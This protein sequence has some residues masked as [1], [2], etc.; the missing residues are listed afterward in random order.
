MNKVLQ[1]YISYNSR[2][3]TKKGKVIFMGLWIIFVLAAAKG[4]F[5]FYVTGIF[6]DMLAWMIYSVSGSLVAYFLLSFFD[7]RRRFTR[8]HLFTMFS[9]A[10]VFAPFSAVITDLSPKPLVTVGLIEEFFKVVPLILFAIFVP[11]IIRTKKD[12]IIYG[13]LGGIGFNI[14]EISLYISRALKDVSVTEAISTHSTRLAIWGFGNHVIWSAF[15]GL[16]IGMFVQSKRRGFKRWLL[17]IGIYLI[18]AV[19]HSAFDLGMSSVVILLISMVLSYFQGTSI[20]DL[21]FSLTTNGIARTS[22]ILEHG[23]YNAIFIAI[24]IWQGV[25]S[26]IWE[27]KMIVKNLLSEHD[28]IVSKEEKILIKNEGDFFSRR[29]RSIPR[30]VSKRLI[31][32]QNLLAMF[33]HYVTEEE[34]DVDSVKEIKDLQHAIIELRKSV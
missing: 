11:N 25:K 19:A 3:K 6:T 8:F 30:M 28:S 12:G 29:Y 34:K 23:V 4:W 16:G 26:V 21:D 13:A 18:V 2:L 1:S 31:K 10:F 9:V 15:V 14:I 27:Q 33:K 22:A 7:N 20:H 5:S 24:L 17:P 32:Y